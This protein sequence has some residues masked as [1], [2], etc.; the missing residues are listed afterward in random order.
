M[1]MPNFSYEI[2]FQNKLSSNFIFQRRDN[3]PFEVTN[4]NEQSVQN[5]EIHSTQNIKN[6][7]KETCRKI[8][9]VKLKSQ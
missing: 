6:Q 1:S 5:P 4:E 8:A 2:S 7:L 9:E 3:N